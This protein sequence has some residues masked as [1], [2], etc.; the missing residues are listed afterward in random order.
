LCP[1]ER[2]GDN[3]AEISAIKCYFNRVSPVSKCF[4][5]NQPFERDIEKEDECILYSVTDLVSFVY[6]ITCSQWSE[7]NLTTN[8]P[9]FGYFFKNDKVRVEMLPS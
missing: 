2:S 6:N 4:S 9:E 7:L 8:R 1:I 3:C 5:L